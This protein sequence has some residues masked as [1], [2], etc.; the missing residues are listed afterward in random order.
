MKLN[1][2]EYGD[3]HDSE[4][5]DTYPNDGG[6]N[7]SRNADYAQTKCSHFVVRKDL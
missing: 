5:E 1:T 4:Y 6:S 7:F 2:Q 3:S